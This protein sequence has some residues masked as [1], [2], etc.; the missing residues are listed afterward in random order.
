MK[1]KSLHRF[2]RAALKGGYMELYAPISVIAVVYLIYLSISF[3]GAYFLSRYYYAFAAVLIWCGVRFIM[4]ALSVLLTVRSR[5]AVI[6]RCVVRISLP[7]GYERSIYRR[8]RRLYLLRELAKFM[9]RILFVAALLF[10]AW[11]IGTDILAVNGVYR[12]LGAFQA[13]PVMIVILWLRMKLSICFAGAEVLAVCAPDQG[14]WKS[15]CE[16]VK[17]LSGQYGFIAG[18]FL[19]NLWEVLLP[20]F[21]PVFIQTLVSYFSVRHIE[22]KYQENHNHEQAHL[23]SMHKRAYKAGDVPAP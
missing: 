3:T 22:W 21:L 6:R 12:L 19:R 14:V 11:I 23:Y 10:G 9:C 20:F 1:Q 8:L 7:C 13:V 4:K 5:A 17:M 16:S 18:I 2:S 15:L